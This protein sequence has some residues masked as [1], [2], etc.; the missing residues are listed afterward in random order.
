DVADTEC[1]LQRA[2]VASFVDDAGFELDDILI[3]IERIDNVPVVL[4][5]YA[6]TQFACAGNLAIVCI[7]LFMQVHKTAY[8][9]FVRQYLIGAYDEVVDKLDHAGLL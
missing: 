2:D 8:V 6:A 5:D 1:A 3:G 7:E 9:K 4:L